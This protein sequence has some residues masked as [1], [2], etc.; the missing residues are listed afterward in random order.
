M[1]KHYYFVYR[2]DF[3]FTIFCFLFLIPVF[4]A[5]KTDNS[6]FLGD[7]SVAEAI[8]FQQSCGNISPYDCSEIPVTLPLSLNFSG[9]G[10][11]SGFTMVSAPS[12]RLYED[13]YGANSTVTGWN[14]NKLNMSNG[15]LTVRATRGS[16][17]GSANSQ[18][19]A[20]GVGLQT[21]SGLINI[22]AKIAQPRFDRSYGDYGQEAGIWYGIDED[23][24]AKVVVQKRPSSWFSS[25][26]QRIRFTIEHRENDGSIKVF[27]IN[28]DDFSWSTYGNHALSFRLEIDPA[29]KEARAFYTI[30]NGNEILVQEDDEEFLNVPS[31]F[32]AGVDHDS[33]GGTPNVSF[34]G[35]ATSTNGARNGYLDVSYDSFNVT[36]EQTLNSAN[37]ITYFE[38]P[39]QLGAA[40]IN[41]S[42][43]TVEAE[44]EVGTDLSSLAPTVLVSQGAT[45]SPE[46]GLPRN[47]TSP[48][49]YTVTAE[50]GN[51]QRWTVNLSADIPEDLRLSFN[52]NALDFEGDYGSSIASQS[53]NVSANT[54]SPEFALSDDP[55]SSDWL[56][57][58]VANSENTY[59]LGQ[60]EFGI[61][62]G[63]SAG[64]YSTVIIATDASG[65]G[66][67]PAS[68]TVSLT[69]SGEA[70]P[71]VDNFEAHIN[72]QD[73]ATIPPSGY[74]KDY[75]KEFGNNS[76][77]I[78]GESFQ[79]GWKN[80]ETKVPFDAS[81][82]AENNSNGVGRN[83][84]GSSYT[85][86]TI[87]EQ[88]E[89]T[90]VHFQGDNILSPNGASQTWITQPRG[91]ELYWELEIPN[92]VYQVTVGLGDES[93]D[94]DS[95]HSATVE[96]Y[97]VIPA[98]MPAQKENRSASIV[99]E[100]TDGLLTINGLGGFNSKINY[101]DV[102][103]SNATPV[104][105]VLSF[106]PNI[107]SVLLLDGTSS[108][109]NATLGG[110]GATAIGM[111]ISDNLNSGN[112]NI[113]DKNDWLALPA[114]YQT[115][116]LAF[117]VTAYSATNNDAFLPGD[118]RN[119]AVVATAKGYKPAVLD[120]DM[121]VQNPGNQAPTVKD[122][123]FTVYKQAA[124]NTALGMVMADDVDND[125]LHF[126]IIGG[127]DS[128][129]FTIDEFSGALQTTGNALDEDEYVLTVGVSD[130]E[131]TAQA[132]I[133]ISVAADLQEFNTVKIN[134]SFADDVP[135]DDFLTDSGKGFGDR[136]N[137]Y[138]YGWLTTNSRP[139]DLS[140]NVRNRNF[141]QLSILQN[142]LLHM[143]Y[144]DT[145]GASG[146]PIE[147]IWEIGLPNGVYQVTVGVGDPSIDGASSIPHHSINAEG[148]N[149]ISDFVPSGAAGSLTRL[150]SGT[151]QV[152]ITDARLTIDAFG[153]FN[154]KINYI[155]ITP[156][157][158]DS[159]A[160]F[161]NVTPADN[162]SEVFISDFQINVD[163]ITPE[164]YELLSSSLMGNVNLYKIVDGV[165]TLVPSNSNDTGGKDAI[166]LTP[167]SFL[168]PFTDYVFRIENVEANKI[169]DLTDKIVFATFE[170]NFT[171]GASDDEV[172][173][174]RDLSGVEFTKIPGGDALGEGTLGMR[175]SSLVIGPDGKLYGSTLGDFQSDGQ[176]YRW[177]IADDG[178]LENLQILSPQ[179]TGA[180]HPVSG[181]RDNNNR[182]IIGLVFDPNSTA[183]DLT[184]YVTHSSA[185]LT[186]GPE[187]DGKLTRLHGP[188]LLETQ[189]I[190]EH[191]PR[192]ISD[193]MT[194]SITFKDGD[195]YFVQGSLSAGG[196]PDAVW[197]NRPES[198]LSAAVLKLDLDKL[199]SSLP[200]SV[201][202]TSNINVIN[203]A[204]S[205]GLTMSDGRYNPYSA[206]SPLTIFATGVRNAYDLVWHSNGWLYMPTNGTA[207]NNETSPNA[208]GSS[209]YV[210]ARR[211]DGVTTIPDV[212]A[213]RGGEAQKDWLFKTQ[214]GS[215]HGHPN[216]YRGEFVLNHG[217]MPYS[218][219]PGQVEPNYID[220]AK[221]PETL[222]PD[223][224][225]RRP[226]YDF[227]LNKSPNGVI[228]YKSHAFGGKLQGLLMVCR[229][230]GQDDLL[231]MD[232]KSNGDIAEVYN[233][234][235]GLRG[236]DD[237]LE[238]VEDVKSGN[239]YISE[240][241]R[242]NSGVARL[243]LL[244]ASATAVTENAYRFNF[245]TASDLA[246]SPYGYIDEVGDA[247]ASHTT[248]DGDLSYG[249]V[250]EGSTVP[251]A[252]TSGR[253]RNN[254]NFNAL[255]NTFI[256]LGHRNT[257]A[258]PPTDWLLN[259]PNGFY[260]VTISV[261][262][263]NYK[264][265]NHVLDVNGV[266]VINFDQQNNNPNNLTHFENTEVVE[267]SDGLLRL[268]LGAAGDNTKIN[269][270]VIVPV[271]TESIPP[272]VAA[273][274]NNEEFVPGI[275][276]GDVQ[277][278]LNVTD[279]SGSGLA[280]VNY[281]LDGGSS[282]TYSNAL[283]V[284][285]A[286]SHTL[287]VTA[288]DNNGNTSIKEYAFTIEEVSNAI[289]YVE[290]MTKIPTTDRGFPA[291]DYY[292]FHRIDNPGRAKRRETNIMRLHNNGSQNLVVS[293]LNISD[294]SKFTYDILAGDDGQVSL[295]L[296]I[297]AG[298]FKDINI[299][300]I[301]SEGPDANAIYRE[302]MNIVSNSDEESNKEIIL[303]GAYSPIPE[304][305]FEIRS[306]WVLDAF[307]FETS[308]LS[309]VNNAG[310]VNPPNS[311][312]NIPSSDYPKAE[313]VNAGFEGDLIISPNF[314][315]ADPSKPVIGFQLAAFHGYTSYGARF[316]SVNNNNTVA[317]INFSHLPEYYQTFFPV[318]QD[319]VN[320]NYGRAESITVP[321]RIQVANYISS[322]NNGNLGVRFYKVKDRDGNVVPNEYIAIEDFIGSGCSTNYGGN[323]DFQDDVFYFVNIRPQAQ[324]S[325]QKIDD[326]TAAKSSN[327]SYDISSYFNVGYAGNKFKFSAD[328][329]SWASINESTGVISGISSS[330]SD[331][332]Y[333]IQVSATDLNGLVVTSNFNLILGEGLTAVDDTANTT[334]NSSITLSS[335]LSND[336]ESDNQTLSIASVSNASHGTT[337][338]Q[339]G[340]RVI[341]TPVN[342][343]IGQDSFTYTVSNTSGASDT[344]MVT[345]TVSDLPQSSGFALRINAGGGQTTYNNKTFEADQYY[346]AGNSYNN[347]SASVPSLYQTE[348]TKGAPASF[349]YNIPVPNGKYSIALHFAE[350]YWGVNGGTNGGRGN[351]IFD[352]GIEGSRVL[353]NYDIIADVGAGNPT[354]KTF[355]VVV[356]DGTLNISFS[357]ESSVGGV[358]QPKI[359]AIEILG[360]DCGPLPAVW[361][362]ADIGAVGAAGE[363]CYT[364]G[365]FD[366]KASGADIWYRADEFHF[367]YQ[368]LQG[369]GEIIARVESLENT[370]EWAKA[371]VMMRNNLNANASSAQIMLSPNPDKI[372]MPGFVF[373]HR[374]S[375]GADMGGNST[376]PVTASS[377]KGYMRL[378]RS[379]NRFTA[380]VSQTNGNWRQIASQTIYMNNT[381]YVGLATTSHSDGNLTT[382]TYSN[383]SVLGRRGSDDVSNT[384]VSKATLGIDSVHDY[385][386]IMHP[387]PATDKV[388]I[389]ITNPLMVVDEI[390][391]HDLKGSV[392][393]EYKATTIKNDNS[394]EVPIYN[395]EAGIYLVNVIQDNGTVDKLKLIVKH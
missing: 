272:T 107:Q 40:V 296:T 222:G 220:V 166:T 55:D 230:S 191:L 205:N 98:F 243:T 355:D 210:L 343:F 147:G 265:S 201:Y 125:V 131:F 298:D 290:N 39:T 369:D 375:D 233:N 254:S 148:V 15:Y 140:R 97:T 53:V 390:V 317:D 82:E 135:S 100:V 17:N 382:A 122:Q 364:N 302:T 285:D 152:S 328:M 229:F 109:F 361:N 360:E 176:I 7:F 288:I 208:P 184:A 246:E 380:Y 200:L 117:E 150:S 165:E 337:V 270:I 217:G 94:I 43:H 2:K 241:D 276:K 177:D 23:N 142:T 13:A 84:L 51:V 277:I 185:V 234:I 133:S 104:S 275:Y 124:E 335:L 119:N 130:G 362:N 213:L 231:V 225:Y 248:P 370:N 90:L 85:G 182:L 219:V 101:V 178:T 284:T 129:V 88:L 269:Y 56:I 74:L 48:V 268:N 79:Y 244:R 87:Q 295:P 394:Y 228:E 251:T 75:G 261:G 391:I 12:S 392:V 57:M 283:S 44:V 197:G 179:L 192:S 196:A 204:P 161:V 378:V 114:S 127:N 253:N 183:D 141:S 180:D 134:F 66:Y 37:N 113:T 19:N 4:S 62:A 70:P 92:G 25:R 232:P 59:T 143:Q 35:I 106:D 149:I 257:V 52:K 325:A 329:P 324:P 374:R 376:T 69:I 41:A 245:Q 38:V 169:G 154:T 190:L 281:V 309:Y 160:Y 116:N 10:S 293:A 333:S 330:D 137:N 30:D 64:T 240:Y 250:Q 47:F 61:Q 96:G 387:N 286:G 77:E 305:V 11:A 132:A 347:S 368:Q 299:L 341:Y 289:L 319:G 173:P 158:I 188:D 112:K 207:G 73:N 126:S 346:S 385:K 72:F 168:E 226:A 18:M 198:L 65:L 260:N 214:G 215:Y 31:N 331:N 247:Y 252:N 162:T 195:I 49:E 83:R 86:A 212:Q 367:V 278:V 155:E 136:G 311:N 287:V 258:Y 186:A 206:D 264:D 363:A 393:A 199:P 156:I 349:S 121:Y 292:T 227:G 60:L 332:I 249:W 312:P 224:N 108:N 170:S 352:V 99:V 266:N 371:S 211:I 357:A 338:L 255:K 50:N 95:R 110:D 388:E 54:G 93:N 282:Q 157:S 354:V 20:L 32:L 356:N 5:E 326:Y 187:W 68:I 386:I 120:V 267:V 315:Q 9:S 22:A 322:G 89:G 103:E 340:N 318:G 320:I 193:H 279:E 238:V 379:G 36:Q 334:V 24:I 345:I 145:G 242:D 14:P 171:T 159:Q 274:F 237:P 235:P 280:S 218:G 313:N 314:V 273:Q 310:N 33:N 67:E 81:N 202:T 203:T 323:C 46:S 27:D 259:I 118:S 151:A 45:I 351:R 63:L 384:N 29:T 21:A 294:V 34:A 321:F 194:N 350:I 111:T 395:L 6:A 16:F 377:G 144:G 372:G 80:S 336:I 365:V 381:I 348:R 291:D 304:D 1:M 76:V 216:P 307:G 172:I 308:M 71:I 327:F 174:I 359:S 358:D 128:D 175:F 339:S 102:I 78:D 153:G 297:A 139:V 271:G 115:G 189:D 138:S 300:F 389:N 167:L 146:E 209:D 163:V 239:L 42:A 256:H 236:F 58:P 123:S 26:K 28:T 373:Q 301:G 164:G 344:A 303:H 353:N 223:I 105:G 263:P 366:V 316:V 306:Q 8:P 3:V 221:Y 262:D 342:N 181:P 91:N 383:V